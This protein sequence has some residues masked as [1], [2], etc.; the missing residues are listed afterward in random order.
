MVR[1]ILAALRTVILV[2]LFFVYTI[3][4]ASIIVVYGVFRPASPIHD[5]IVK[6]W[7]RLFLKIPPVR[8]SVDGL[9]NV[10]P[11]KRY[12]IVSNHLSLFDIPTLFWTLPVHGR[13]L[14][15]KE[16]FK[17]PMVGRA[18][19]TIGIVEINRASG[20]SSRQAIIEGV[21]I[22]AERGFSLIVFP[23]GTRGTGGELLPFMKG[24]F[25][26]AIDTGL[27]ILPVIIE[28]TERV[29]RSGSRL[30]FPGSARVVI[31]EPIETAHMTNKNDL[32]DLSRSVEAI[33]NETYAMLTPE[34]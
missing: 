32:K 1:T 7:A 9:D 18:M 33:M 17:I 3:I 25:R 2:P 4:E 30:F 12:M 24:A 8:C 16:V 23:E 29:S 31:L 10:D 34:A 26:I 28:G 19:R 6:R 20:G 27:P 22:A 14:S 13:F 15:K 11:T 21:Q 5:R